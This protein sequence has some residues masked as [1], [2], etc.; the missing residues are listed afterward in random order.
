MKFE[1]PRAL[2]CRD[3]IREQV[4]ML[5]L[6]GLSDDPRRSDRFSPE[7]YI[8]KRSLGFPFEKYPD[9]TC[10]WHLLSLPNQRW[11]HLFDVIS[12]IE[13]LRQP[14]GS[15]VGAPIML[16]PFQLL[17]LQA[18]LGPEDPSTGL[19]VV[20]EGVLT[21][22]RK[23]AKSCL[24]AAL[25]VA[26]MS[27]HPDAHGFIGQDLQCG[28]ADREQAGILYG[29]A[30]RFV[31]LDQSPLALASRFHPVPSKKTLTH[32]KTKS[33]LRALSADAYRAL[34]GN[35]AMV[36]LDEIGA[37][38]GHQA[39]DFYSALT[40]GFGAQEE[41]LTLLLSTQAPVDQHFFSTMVDKCRRVND[42]MITDD[43]LAGFC[44]DLP[45]TDPATGEKTDP[46]DESLW[47]LSAP[48]I[49]TIYRRQDMRDWAKKAKDLPALEN[50]YRNLKLNQRVSETAAF[51]SRTT[52]QRNAGRV[53]PVKL[54]GKACWLG[55]DLS[56]TTDLTALVALFEPD[57]D[58]RMAV[59]CWFWIPGEGLDARSHRDKVPY[60][61]WSNAGL[62]DTTSSHSVDYTKVA[63]KIKDLFDEYNVQA[64]GFDRWR[65]KRL[66]KALLD[67]DVEPYEGPT[68][69]EEPFYIPV[70][71]GFKDQSLTVELLETAALDRRLIHDNPILTWCVANTVIQT[72]PAGGRK[73]AKNRSYGRV[74][75]TVALGVAMHAKH[76][77]TLED[78]GGS[79]YNDPTRT[80]IM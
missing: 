51:L 17:I 69:K 5:E 66:R 34:G 75:G 37:V 43:S 56:E 26:L 79:A 42:G 1:N 23:Q 60:S 78:D 33:K 10:P 25:V 9:G 4:R 39:E 14:T 54:A 71:Q 49:D 31:M 44:F 29:M 41:P 22:A 77:Q 50:K 61:A 15:K 70:G 59:L 35:P 2:E 67:L 68:G 76:E 63:Q 46:F 73:I 45:E 36:I 47:F 24:I 21:I 65:V 57:D 32:K 12:I 3:K 19:R 72:D 18:F 55:A 7:L 27:L 30:E 74:D 64:F 13:V 40:T 80:M 53:D 16:Q 20:K 38:P 62:I 48:G 11:Q 52:W 6:W 28:A 58:G 8:R